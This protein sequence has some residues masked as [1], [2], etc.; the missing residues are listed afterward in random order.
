M[1]AYGFHRAAVPRCGM[2]SSRAATRAHD[3]R[4]LA[5]RREVMPI[6]HSSTGSSAIAGLRLP[7]PELETG[8]GAPE[9]V[10]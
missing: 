2:D 7:C 3:D 9:R 6:A 8:Y 10:A 4:S 1:T 5:E